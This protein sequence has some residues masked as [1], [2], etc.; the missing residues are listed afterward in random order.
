MNRLLTSGSQQRGSVRTVTVSV[1]QAGPTRQGIREFFFFNEFLINIEVDRKL[2]KKYLE[3]SPKY[4]NPCGDRL[5]Y[6]SQVL[7]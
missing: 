4:E 5:G 3:T 1:G 7:Y 6:L 2:G